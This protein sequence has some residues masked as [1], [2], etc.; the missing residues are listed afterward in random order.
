MR[1]EALLE[2]QERGELGRL[3]ASAMPGTGERTF[4]RWRDRPRDRCPHD[5]RRACLIT[6]LPLLIVI[7]VI[8]LV[9]RLLGGVFSARGLAG[10]R[11]LKPAP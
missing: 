3:E 8:L 1:F 11:C 9:R 5:C 7:A 2:R 4:R 10:W 6:D